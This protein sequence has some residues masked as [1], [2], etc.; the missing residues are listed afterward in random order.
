MRGYKE[1]LLASREDGTTVSRAYSGKTMRV[2]ANDYTAHFE[3][4]PEE[5]G[6]VPRAVGPGRL[7]RRAPPRGRRADVADVDPARECYPAGQ[8]VG[9]IDELVPA[10]SWSAG[11]W[12]RP[13]RSTT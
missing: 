3:A 2:M 11:S 8:G 13:R 9:G 1:A 7:R 6:T 5:V 10:G 4:H 12:P